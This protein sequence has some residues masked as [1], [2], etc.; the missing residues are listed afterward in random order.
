MDVLIV[1]SCNILMQVAR[2]AASTGLVDLRSL[3]L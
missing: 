1:V 3:G 2:P